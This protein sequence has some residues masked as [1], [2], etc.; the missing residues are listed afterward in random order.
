MAIFSPNQ[1]KKLQLIYIPFLKVFLS[2]LTIYT[3]LHWYFIIHLEMFS[4]GEKTVN[5]WIPAIL[6]F[7]IVLIF[8]RPKARLLALKDRSPDFIIILMLVTILAPTIILQFY[9]VTATG[10]L[11]VLNDIL[12]KPSTKPTKYYIV[13][14]YFLNKKHTS[15]E[16]ATNISGKYNRDYYM[17]LY[18]AL[19][20]LKNEAD[21]NQSTYE[22]WYC[23]KYYER[24]SNKLSSEMKKQ[25]FDR[26]IKRSFAKFDS[27]DVNNFV[28]L[29][30]IEQV[31]DK[32]GYSQAIENNERFMALHPTI[33]LPINEP[34][35]RRN[36]N[37]L[38]WFLGTL[39]TLNMC[40][41]LFIVKHDL[42]EEIKP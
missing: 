9:V 6:S 26:F 37:K 29:N 22:N 11:T 25:K 14:N 28:Y 36:G 40:L 2:F 13:K 3:L 12:E 16:T 20:I 35:E 39:I 23:V 33:L 5:A 42:K 8:L 34:F 15:F 17:Y 27:L 32:N 30:R 31:F 24:I 1:N 19:P 7:G 41:I 21:T 38:Y 4:I 10:K 18:C